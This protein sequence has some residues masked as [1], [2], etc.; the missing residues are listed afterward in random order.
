MTVQQLDKLVELLKQKR[1]EYEIAKKVAADCNAECEK[2]ENTIKDTLDKL[3]KNSYEA[4]GIGRVSKV[5]RLVYKTPKTI[6]AK[7][8]L[9][10]YISSKYGSDALTGL[11]S[12]N[13]QTLNS[14][15]QKEALEV[16]EI[17]GLD[18][19]SSDEYLRFTDKGK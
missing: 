18:L 3:G 4:E 11:V 10:N 8:S 1:S 7:S 14:W 2:I 5:T 16:K 19:P 12:I 6:A 13:H 15:A 17:P 9:F